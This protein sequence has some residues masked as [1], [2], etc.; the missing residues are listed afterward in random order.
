MPTMS[1]NFML[2]TDGLAAAPHLPEKQNPIF[3]VRRK[4]KRRHIVGQ[5]IQVQ[6]I[7][8]F[9]KHFQKFRFI[10]AKA[11]F[12]IG[13]IGPGQP[14]QEG[15]I[16]QVASLFPLSIQHRH[17]FLSQQHRRRRGEYAPENAKFVQDDDWGFVVLLFRLAVDPNEDFSPLVRAE[18]GFVKHF[19]E[20]DVAMERPPL[21]H[22]VFDDEPLVFHIPAGGFHQCLEVGEGQAEIVEVKV[23]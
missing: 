20:A 11:F 13:E 15:N 12:D 9:G 3:L 1:S 17:H 6:G 19:R 10:H 23:L 4:Q 22:A 8:S 16:E 7:Q 14:H 18:S 21:H 2:L 5:K